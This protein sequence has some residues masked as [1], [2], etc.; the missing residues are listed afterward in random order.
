MVYGLGLGFRD[1]GVQLRVYSTCWYPLDSF[2]GS[3]KDSLK[4][5]PIPKPLHLVVRMS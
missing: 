5:N 3:F 4:E 2:K 1:L